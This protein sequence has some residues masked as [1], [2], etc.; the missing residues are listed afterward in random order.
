M[1]CLDKI[2]FSIAQPHDMPEILSFVDQAKKV[3][4]SQGIFQ[5]DKIY[6]TIIDFCPD[7]KKGQVYV[8]RINGIAALTFTI[9]KW[10]DQAYLTAD[11]DYKGDE[12]LVIH[13]LCVNPDF[14]GKG[15][16]K[17]ACRFIEGLA[18]SQGIKSIRLDC[19]TKNPVSLRLYEGLGYKVRG[20]AD[21][22]MGRFCLME[23]EL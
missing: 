5:W 2:E 19:F 18:K 7:V 10:Q 1:N 20:Y 4:D 17:A 8:G 13:R 15:L 6:P 12:F 3:M 16:G 9:N 21:W 14:Q 23:K 11:W 22:R